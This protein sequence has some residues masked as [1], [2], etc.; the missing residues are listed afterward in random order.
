MCAWQGVLGGLHANAALAALTLHKN[1]DSTAPTTHQAAYSLCCHSSTASTVADT[2]HFVCRT[3]ASRQGQ[4]DRTAWR[5]T[6]IQMAT[7]CHKPAA[8]GAACGERCYLRQSPSPPLLNQSLPPPPP[9]TPTPTPPHPTPLLV[10]TP[11]P[12]NQ[13][14]HQPFKAQ[15]TKHYVPIHLWR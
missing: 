15:V 14:H 8:T 2:V 11:P 13:F 9:Q 6:S 4:C 7:P 5:H 12:P 3:G 1:E 10:Y